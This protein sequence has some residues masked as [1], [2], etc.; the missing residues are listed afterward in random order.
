MIRV[1]LPD[2]ERRLIEAVAID[3]YARRRAKGS[4]HRWNRGAEHTIEKETEAIGA[5]VACAIALRLEWKDSA[6][7]DSADG[8]LGNGI[9]VRHTTH[10][11]GHL[12]IYPE[13][14]PAH[15]YFLV[16]GHY[17]DYMVIGFIRA[18]LGKRVGKWSEMQAGRPC[19]MVGQKHLI[20]PDLWLAANPKFTQA[21]AR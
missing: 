2:S 5:E 16:T 13:D 17:P 15:T 12:L 14:N 6:M 19:F 1:L 8:D 18:S 21:S 3:R 20:H 4:A 7:P 11:Q 10:A 9:E